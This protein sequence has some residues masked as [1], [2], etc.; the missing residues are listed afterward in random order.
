MEVCSHGRL[1]SLQW[2]LTHILVAASGP[3][4]N[5]PG[6]GTKLD[7]LPDTEHLHLATMDEARTWK[8]S[9]EQGLLARGRLLLKY[10]FFFIPGERPFPFYGL[11][12]L[13]Q[14]K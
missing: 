13:K 7:P 8:F 10:I 11:S 9:I 5:N 6:P 4:P 1:Q 3:I 12:Q 2:T 14:R